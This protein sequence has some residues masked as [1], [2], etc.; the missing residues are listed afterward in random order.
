MSSVQIISKCP[1]QILHHWIIT[2]NNKAISEILFFT[3]HSVLSLSCHMPHRH[4]WEVELQL[5]QN[6]T[7][8][9]ESGWSAPCPSHF[10]SRKETQYPL[11]RRPAQSSGPVW[12]GPDNLTL[13]KVRTLDHPPHSQSLY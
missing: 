3:F 5:Y 4:R 7:P 10:T 8:A 2:S 13:T 12:M 6:L 1:L 9:Q 11:Y